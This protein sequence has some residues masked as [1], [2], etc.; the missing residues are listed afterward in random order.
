MDWIK[1]TLYGIIQGLT[2]FLPVSSSGHLALLPKIMDFKDPGVLFDLS[3]HVGT[4]VAIMVYFHKDLIHMAKGLFTVIQEKRVTRASY[5]PINM[6]ISTVSTLAVVLLIKDLAME[7]GRASNL[8]GINLIAFGILMFI[9]DFR[10]TKQETD[11][12]FNSVRPIRALMIGLFQAL[13]IF[14]GVS[15]SGSTLTISRFMG[16]SRIESTRYSF[17]LS[18]PIIV[19]GFIFKLPDMINGEQTFK[20]APC[21]L[22]GFV[23]F[24]VGLVTIHFF[25]KLISRLGLGVFA[26]YRIFLGGVVFWLL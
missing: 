3:M 25:L 5:H 1:A 14:P 24:G 2:E 17:L 20:L 19:G 21:L 26:L 15:R 12:M 11:Y 6:I 23:S 9:S 8:I 13:A 16:L 10:G 4:A 22:G 7:H 18:L